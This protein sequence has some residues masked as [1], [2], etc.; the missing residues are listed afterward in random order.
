MRWVR[1]TFSFLF[2][3][4]I[5]FYNYSSMKRYTYEKVFQEET[6]L[7]GSFNELGFQKTHFLSRVRGVSRIFSIISGFKEIRSSIS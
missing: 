4:E 5:P 6:S 3:G 7:V 1:A 2:G